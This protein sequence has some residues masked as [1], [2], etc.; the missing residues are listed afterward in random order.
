VHSARDLL[1]AVADGEER[2]VEL[3]GALARAVLEDAIVQRAIALEELLR[4]RSPF[5]LV[6]AVELAEALLEAR[7][8]PVPVEDNE[9]VTSGGQRSR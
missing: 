5:A 8:T 9:L 4:M 2:S 1:V 7:A 6:R 3:A